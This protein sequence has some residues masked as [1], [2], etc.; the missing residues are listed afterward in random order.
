[1]N[2]DEAEELI[3]ALVDGALPNPELASL[4]THLKACT[5]CRRVL[6]EERVLKRAT[7]RTGERVQA[8]ETLR[9]KISSDPRIFPARSSLRSWRDFIWPVSSGYRPALAS[10]LVIAVVLSAFYFFS[11]KTEPIAIFAL[12]S[13]G[14]I[15]KGE[16]PVQKTANPHEISERL[17]RA[18][19]GRFHPMGYDFSTMD[20]RPVAG[21]VRE[22]QGRKLLIAIYQGESD[23]IFCFTFVG[24]EE[25]APRNAARFFDPDKKINFYAFS[26]GAVNAVLHREGEVI[27]ILASEMP[28]NK[29]LALAQSKTTPS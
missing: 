12:E 23:A 27:C 9:A 18:V 1:M 2:C 24:N 13:Y 6:N 5:N 29:L 22:I 4:E 3:T 26:S 21:L 15:L 25:D 11:E 7:R 10:A 8:P 20:L 17:T 19:G 16:L 14:L 28:M